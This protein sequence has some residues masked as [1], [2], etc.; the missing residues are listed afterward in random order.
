MH[1]FKDRTGRDWPLEIHNTAIVRCRTLLKEDLPNLV[2]GDFDK[3]YT[4]LA[5]DTDNVIR[6]GSILYVLCQDQADKLGMTSEDF[7]RLLYGDVLDQAAEAFTAELFDFFRDPRRRAG[8]KK[9][10]AAAKEVQAKVLSQ[11]QTMLDQI[12]TDELAQQVIA[13]ASVNGLRNGH[14]NSPASSVSTPDLSPSDSS[15]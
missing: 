8:M 10:M 5:E 11:A 14:G 15:T 6:F 2:D 7:G 9:V 13:E 4:L 1:T 3:L 12:N